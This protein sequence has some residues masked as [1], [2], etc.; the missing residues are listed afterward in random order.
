MLEIQ[1][2][3]GLLLGYRPD[4]A[5]M[6]SPRWGYWDIAPRA[7]PRGG[8]T[9]ISPRWGYCSSSEAETRISLISA[10]F[11]EIICICGD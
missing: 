7:K 11:A 2:A 10:F 4:G 1:G 6:M 8:V 5:M 3:V 9:M